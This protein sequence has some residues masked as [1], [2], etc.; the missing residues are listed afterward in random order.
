MKCISL[1]IIACIS[2]CAKGQN[3][4]VN[5]PAELKKAVAGARPGDT[6]LLKDKEWSDA[7]LQLS[8]KGTAEKPILIMPQHPGGVLISGR[9]CL[10]IGGEYLVIKDLHFNNG[11]TP[12]RGLIT[13]R[14][15]NELLANHCRVSGVLIENFSQPQRFKSDS[16]VILYGKYN[17]IDHSTFVNKLNAGPTVIAELDDERSQQNYHSIDSNYFKGRERFGSNGGET[18]RI[19]VSRYSLSPSRTRISHNYFERCNGEVEI[20]SIKSSENEVSFNTFYECEGSLVLRHG[21]R[22]I[23]NGNYFI[24]NNKAFTGGVR[25]INPGHRVFNNVFYHLQGTGFRAALAVLNG[26]PNSLINRYYQVTD[27]LIENNTFAGCAS[28]LF[29]AGKDAERTLSP[30]RVSFRKNLVTAAVKQVYENANA[31]AGVSFTDNILGIEF[32]A[33]APAG[34]KKQKVSTVQNNGYDLPFEQTHG[35]TLAKTAL[36]DQRNSGAGWYRPEASSTFRKAKRFEIAAA[37]ADDI[38]KIADNALAGDTILLKDTGYYQLTAEVIIRKPLLIMAAA[39]LKNRPVFVSTSDKALDAFF[40]IANGGSLY[41]R[42]IA[43]KGTFKTFANAEAGIRSAEEPMNKHYS[44]TADNCEFYDFNES[45]QSGIKG[46]KGTLADSIIVLNSI[47]HHISGSGINLSEEKDD[48]GI[49]SAE[50]T[51]VKN[52]VF[53]NLLGSAITIYRGGND[54]STLGPFAEIDHCTFNEVE[55]R[56]QGTVVRLIGVQYAK[57][58]NSVFLNSGQGGRAILFQEYRWDR[59]SVDHCNFYHSGKIE[60]FY[61]KAAGKHIYNASPKSSGVL[62]SDDDQPLGA[63]PRLKTTVS[64]K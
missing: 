47:F 54:E 58:S 34:F 19:G 9:S 21:Y 63:D 16:W 8:G 13:F 53:S 46:S 24:G 22:N 49:Y 29:G 56:E 50:H 55:N 57:V 26:V 35:A 32:N 25:I 6:I 61:N 28:I 43:F 30:Q 40:S 52:C 3:I 15:N 36:A 12:E 2:F 20:V 7:L 60:S 23:V 64:Y 42:G 45:T 39:K 48:K 51:G 62:L 27:V 38:Q 14:I 10:Q 33:Q 44:L 4:L 18:I 31:D 5:T 41:I 37:R 1:L 17:R 59:I 11:F